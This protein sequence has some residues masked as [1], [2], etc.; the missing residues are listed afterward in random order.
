[1]KMAAFG[2]HRPDTVDE[3]LS[4]LAAH[5]ADGKILAGGQ[6]L[7]AMMAMRMSTP[8]HL[9]D[10]GTL[11]GLS[12]VT[13][14]DTHVA[15]GSLV[16]QSAAEVSP[17]LAA[18]APLVAKAVPW[19]GHR[20]IRNRGTVCGSLAHADPAAELPSVALALDAEFVL[21]SAAGSRT[22]P[23]AQFFQSFLTTAIADDEMLTEVRF[24]RWPARSGFAVQ[25]ISRRHGDFA[26]VG[27]SVGLG[28]DES[29][30]IARAAIALFGV[31]GTAVRVGAAEQL[32]VGQRPA[33]EAFAA[34]AAVVCEQLEPAGD[35]HATGAYR[36]HVAGVLVRRSLQAAADDAKGQG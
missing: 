17:E 14:D 16:R 10:I 11:P 29:G 34:A 22:V 35:D 19:I 21:R 5:G 2:Y 3:A 33:A 32:L 28:I 30:S 8:A 7:L 24:A 4:L 20:A 36:R 23:A 18:A 31:A 27:A 12:D 25:E 15:V 6:S 26:L 9:I 13:V 1:M